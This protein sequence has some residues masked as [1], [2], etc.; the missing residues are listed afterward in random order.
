M[1]DDLNFYFE[2]FPDDIEPMKEKYKNLLIA[3]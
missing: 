2:I 3:K 1:E